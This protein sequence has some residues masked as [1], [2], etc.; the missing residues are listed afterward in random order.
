MALGGGSINSSGHGRRSSGQQSSNNS[1][2]NNSSNNNNNIGNTPAINPPQVRPQ[3]SCTRG[4]HSSRVVYGAALERGNKRKPKDPRLTN[5]HPFQ[6]WAS[7]KKST[8][9]ASINELAIVAD[10]FNG[11]RSRPRS[12]SFLKV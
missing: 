7:L 5:P 2:G 10:E 1:S 6:G 4:R 12:H 3:Q 11:M 9:L 8:L